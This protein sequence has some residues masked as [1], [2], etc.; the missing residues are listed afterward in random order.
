MNRP[1][2]R[3]AL[4]CSM[5]LSLAAAPARAD[6]THY[7]DILVGGRA[8]G[9]GG[10]FT[11]IADDPSGAYYNP[12]GLADARNTNLQVSTSLYGFERGSIPKGVISPV[13]GVENLKVQ[14][15]DLIIVPASAGFVKTFGPLDEEGHPYQAY[16]LSVVVPSFRSFTIT[17]SNQGDTDLGAQM[18]SS[19]QRRVTDRELWSGLGYGRRVTGRLRLGLSAYYVLRSVADRE[20]VSVRERGPAG[21]KFQSVTND[22]TFLNGSLLAILGARFTLDEHWA[23]GASLQSP[24]VPLHSQLRLLFSS[25]VSDPTAA[26]GPRSSLE[27]VSVTGKSETRFAPAARV[28]A[29]YSRKY[30]YLLSADVSYHAPVDYTVVEPRAADR[31]GFDDNR[32]RLPFDPHIS[33]RGVVNVNAGAEFLVIREVSLAGGIFTD[34][35]SAPRNT[36]A[37]MQDQAAH[38]NLMGLSMSIGYF[39]QHTL[40]RLGVL[41]SFGTG[42]DVIPDSDIGRVL[43]TQQSFRRVKYFQSFFY[44]FLSSTFRY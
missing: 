44:V 40:S 1:A 27:S 29:S 2:R 26:G 25:A 7:Q 23:L 8:I 36:S 43:E 34:F 15:T 14:F 3:F 32:R 35:S 31:Q 38:V 12:A 30:K 11:S 28:G 6:D 13:P 37:P 5:V 9:L 39:G 24:S 42:T 18:L 41:Y 17:D 33:R 21:D 16:A 19:Y 20:D 22:I 4:A 10:A